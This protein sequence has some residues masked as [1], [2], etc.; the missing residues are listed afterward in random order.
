MRQGLYLMLLKMVL[1]LGLTGNRRPGLQV[2]INYNLG[3]NIETKVKNK[4][5]ITYTVNVPE[6]VKGIKIL[7]GDRFRV[8]TVYELEAIYLFYTL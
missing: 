8:Y 2:V 1:E 6:L 7:V 5:N 4:Q 3:L